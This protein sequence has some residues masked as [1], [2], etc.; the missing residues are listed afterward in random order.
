MLDND[1][2]EGQ[3]KDLAMEQLQAR[4]LEHS[5]QRIQQIKDFAKLQPDHPYAKANQHVL[6]LDTQTSW[7]SAGVL[8]M[9]GLGWWALN[10]SADVSPPH[11][12]IYNAT[13]GPDWDIALFT[14][15]VAG[16]FL[17]EPSSLHGDLDF[18]LQSVAGVAGEVSF[19]LYYPNNG[20]HVASFLGVVLGFSVSKITGSGSISY[21]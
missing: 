13:G 21:H 15:S 6:E 18:T 9:S 16:Y 10:L 12:L 2:Y 11:Y 3:A 17:V 4:A 1:T 5:K 20:G 8:S 14:S 7:D 19:D